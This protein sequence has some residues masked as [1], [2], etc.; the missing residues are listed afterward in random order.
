MTGKLEIW[1]FWRP[2]GGNFAN[3]LHG[4]TCRTCFSKPITH[5]DPPV[6]IPI[7]KEKH[8]IMLKLAAFYH[9]LLKIRQI[10]VIWA[11]SPLMKT[12]QISRNSTCKERHIYVYHVSVRTPPGV[13]WA[14]IRMKKSSRKKK[15]TQLRRRK[16]KRMN[17]WI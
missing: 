7:S 5:N 6:S 12:Y 8:P 13:T 2:A 14:V 9:N 11:P 16:E 3:S 17:F 15:K 4:F 10:H 1:A